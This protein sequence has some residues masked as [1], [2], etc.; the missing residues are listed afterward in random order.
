M[1]EKMK[2]KQLGEAIFLG[3][4]KGASAH[5]SSSNKR[6][7]NGRSEDTKADGPALS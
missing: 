7:K 3:G 5:A 6:M 2:A 4:R 1:G